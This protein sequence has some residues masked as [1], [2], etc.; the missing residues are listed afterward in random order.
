MTHTNDIVP[1]LPP[2]LFGFTH[3]SPEYW[4]TSANGATVGG[5]D[6]ELVEGVGSR[7]GNAGE[8]K[9]SVLAHS[10]YFVSIFKCM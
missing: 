6:V 7:G 4:I 9:Q 8:D 5:S 2:S 1:R 3:W 10:W